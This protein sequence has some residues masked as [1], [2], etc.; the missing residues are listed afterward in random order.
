MKRITLEYC[1]HGCRKCSSWRMSA[2][3]ADKR[4][5]RTGSSVCIATFDSPRTVW[6]AVRRYPQPVRLLARIVACRCREWRCKPNLIYLDAS[7]QHSAPLL[8]RSP[9]SYSNTSQVSRRTCHPPHSGLG[10]AGCP[11]GA[12]AGLRQTPPTFQAPYLS[13]KMTGTSIK[14]SHMRSQPN[15][16]RSSALRRVSLAC[17]VLVYI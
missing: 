6:G 1:C 14:M 16:E 12:P 8:F 7:A 17:F 10:K 2:S 5:H 3:H 4:Y 11:G 13:V 9:L 15:S